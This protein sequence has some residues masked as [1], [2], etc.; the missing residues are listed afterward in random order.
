MIINGVPIQEKID[1]KDEL[2]YSFIKQ[3]MQEI[4][5]GGIDIKLTIKAG[6]V[7]AVKVSNER[8]INLG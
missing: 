2:W 7:T 5:Y 6:K 4:D 8:T 3:Q 1:K